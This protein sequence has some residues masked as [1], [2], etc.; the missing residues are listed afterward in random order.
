MDISRLQFVSVIHTGR[1]G[2]VWKTA[3]LPS[4]DGNEENKTVYG[5][6]TF[7]QGTQRQYFYAERDTYST[8]MIRNHLNIVNCHGWGMHYTD[9]LALIVLEY[10]PKGCLQAYLSVSVSLFKLRA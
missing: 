8:P 2:D 4:V 7:A 9:D 5:V 10:C 3:L 1:F 6:K